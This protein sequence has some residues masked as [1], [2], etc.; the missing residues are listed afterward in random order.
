M[1]K[2]NER[3]YINANSNCYVL[4]EKTKIQDKKSKNFGK[5]TYKDLGY[6]VTI[7]NV[8]EGILKKE[9]REYINKETENNLK[10]LKEFIKEKE[11]HLKS[12]KL[13]I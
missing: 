2:I 5:E 13:D 4:Q 7:E 9:I 11:K 6:Y 12:L 8:L 1:I 10:D 3:Y